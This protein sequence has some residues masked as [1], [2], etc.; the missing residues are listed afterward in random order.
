MFHKARPESIVFSELME[1]D[2][3][4]PHLALPLV[5]NICLWVTTGDS[6]HTASMMFS[7]PSQ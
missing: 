3:G 6:I 1:T 4:D 7:S 2:L 5:T